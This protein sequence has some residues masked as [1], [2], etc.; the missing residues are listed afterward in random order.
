[1]IE[2]SLSLEALALGWVT[3][4]VVGF[5]KT[6]VPATGMLIVPLMMLVLPPKLALGALLPLLLAADVFAVCYFRRD[7]HWGLLRM[8]LPGCA[9]GMA[10][11]ATLLVWASDAA[12]KPLLGGLIL[13]LLALQWVRS[14]GL[15]PP[16]TEARRAP[17]V[18]GSLTGLATTIGNAGPIMSLFLLG[19]GLDKDAYMG[20][21]AWL[22]LIVNALKVPLFVQ[23]GLLT[24]ETLLLDALLAPG[25]AIGIVMGLVV[26]SRMPQH[27]FT[28]VSYGLAG[29]AAVPLLVGA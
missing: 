24:R 7:A 18:F 1:V 15:A 11:A 26:L 13:V 29:I 8:L 16:V 9:A 5:G 21:T 19:R 10:I 22:F 12:L 25:I 23:L 3:A 27:L 17:L 28:R 6:G 2:L 20:T 4:A 14:R